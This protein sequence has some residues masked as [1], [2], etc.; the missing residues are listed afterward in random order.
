MKIQVTMLMYYCSFVYIDLCGT[1]FVC[2]SVL[3]LHAIS[4]LQWLLLWKIQTSIGDDE[5]VTKKNPTVMKSKLLRKKKHL[6][7]NLSQK[8]KFVK[9]G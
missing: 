5:T 7:L 2:V 9:I 8:F 1:C 4:I 6:L 3:A